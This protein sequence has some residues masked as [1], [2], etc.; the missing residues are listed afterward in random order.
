MGRSSNIYPSLGVIITI[1]RYI[2]VARG[3]FE[4]HLRQKRK[5]IFSGQALHSY[6]MRCR[7]H[8]TEMCPYLQKMF[9]GIYTVIVTNRIRIFFGNL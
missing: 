5:H 4:L 3:T 7:A 6:E 9:Y 8:L 1:V 2:S